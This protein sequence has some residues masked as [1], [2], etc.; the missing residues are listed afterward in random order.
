MQF[1]PTIVRGQFSS[2]DTIQGPSI[3]ILAQKSKSGSLRQVDAETVPPTMIA[4]R[5][6]CRCMTKVLL[7]IATVDVSTRSQAS[8]QGMAREQGEAF[9]F[10]QVAPN[11]SVQYGLLDQPR[12]MLVGKPRIKGSQNISGRAYEQRPKTDLGKVQPLVKRMHRACLLRRSAANL[13]LAPAGLGIKRE[14]CA[15]VHDL[16]PTAAVGRVV[17]VDIK[18]DDLGTSQP[19]RIAKDQNRS[20]AQPAQV[21]GEG[22]NHGEN[23]IAQDGFFL[24]WWAGMLP[25]DPGQH[26]GNMTVLANKGEAALLVV[27]GKTGETPFDGRDRDRWSLANGGSQIRQI[28]TDHFQ[29]GWQG[30]RAFQPAPTGEMFPVGGIG[31]IGVPSRRGLG[32]VAGSI[33]KAIKS[34]RACNMREQGD[35]IAFLLISLVAPS[36]ITCIRV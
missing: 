13:N 19:A 11:A 18:A 22:G 24:H 3:T 10:W 28:E 5:H 30:V 23:V 20:I 4:P 34:A 15:V 1:E 17:I 32:V 26:R 12:D 27:P 16:N 2:R 6:L 21:K 35:A 31:L 9:L 8:P 14:Q 33:N 29:R 25:L 36:S 7:D